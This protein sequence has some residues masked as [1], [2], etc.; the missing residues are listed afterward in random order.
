[1]ARRS[2]G[3]SLRASSGSRVLRV[4]W[5]VGAVLALA[6]FSDAGGTAPGFGCAQAARHSVIQ[7]K[8]EFLDTNPL[9]GPGDGKGPFTSVRGEARPDKFIEDCPGDFRPPPRTSCASV[10]ERSVQAQCNPTGAADHA[11]ITRNRQVRTLRPG[12][13]AT[14]AAHP[15]HA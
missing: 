3:R 7:A 6:V 11:R 12:L 4:P 5:P 2:G 8:S 15:R 13:P 14:R 9:R 1:S 10:R